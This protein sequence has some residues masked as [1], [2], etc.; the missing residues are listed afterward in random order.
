MLQKLL[1]QVNWLKIKYKVKAALRPTYWLRLKTTDLAWDQ[2]LWDL[3]VRGQIEYVGSF[4][5]IIGEHSVW[6]E[7]HPYA[8]GTL[9]LLKK[10][11]RG[12]SRATVVLLKEELSKAILLQKLKG[13]GPKNGSRLYHSDT[14]HVVL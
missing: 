14:G 13:L 11:E 2:E 4:T 10:G 6:I 7:N 1:T 3:L 5:A 9:N 12:C 8:S